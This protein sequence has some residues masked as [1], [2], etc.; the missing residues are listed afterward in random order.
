MVGVEA[1]SG[2][3]ADAAPYHA[4]PGAQAAGKKGGLDPL[5]SSVFADA[6]RLELIDQK[7]EA[8][9]DATGLSATTRSAHYARRLRDGNRRYRVP[10][11]PKLTL[12]CHTTTHLIAAALSGVGPGYDFP[13]FEPAMLKA[14]WNL[15]IDRLLADSGYDSEANHCMAREGLGIRSTVIA[16]NPR[17]RGRRW[18]KARYRRQMKR[19]FHRRKYGQRWQAESVFSRLK[20]R[21]GSCLRGRSDEA[22]DRETYLKV[23][24][25][26]LMILAAAAER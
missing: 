16:L 5:L 15:P 12:V 14:A 18:P 25:L 24:T 21:L 17:N 1:G 7:P 9:I 4:F 11:H 20:R 26:N 3:Q 10:K 13:L 19:R 23:L 6:H 22:R 8:A 2:A